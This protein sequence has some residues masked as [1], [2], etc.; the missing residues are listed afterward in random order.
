MTFFRH[1]NGIQFLLFNFKILGIQ[2]IDL[3][4]IVFVSLVSGF[5]SKK[6]E[7]IYFVCFFETGCNLN[8]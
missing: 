1:L 8:E 7:H 4:K 6:S 3:V 2:N 5:F